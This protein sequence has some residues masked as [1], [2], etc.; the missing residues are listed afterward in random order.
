M[1]GKCCW[2]W[3]TNFQSLIVDLL[4]A[5]DTEFAFLIVTATINSDAAEAKRNG[6]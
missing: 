1:G 2:F 4:T 6:P 3:V 5:H